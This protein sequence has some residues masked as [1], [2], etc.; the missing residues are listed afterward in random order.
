MLLKY[1][2]EPPWKGSSLCPYKRQEH[3]FVEKGWNRHG[4]G[5]RMQKAVECGPALSMAS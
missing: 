3:G 4:K 2:Y 1:L 5:V